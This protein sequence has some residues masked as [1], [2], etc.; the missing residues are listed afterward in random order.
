VITVIGNEELNKI[1][2]SQKFELGAVAED[3]AGRKF[4]FVKYNDGDGD[5]DGVAGQLVLGLDS[6]YP[7]W[8]CTMDYSSSTVPALSNRQMGFLQAA[9]THGTYGWIQTHGPSRKAMLTD[10]G[11]SQNDLI[12]KHAT[13]DGGIDTLSGDVPI[14]GVALEAD[15]STALAVGNADIRI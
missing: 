2:S 15:S 9:L 3:V 12:M 13:T 4:R 1:Y 10:G 8:E 5:V 11:I 14:L 7:F 6:A